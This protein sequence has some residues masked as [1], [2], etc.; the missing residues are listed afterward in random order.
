MLSVTFISFLGSLAVAHAFTASSGCGVALPAGTKQGSTGSSNS[1]SITSGGRTRSFLLHVPTNYNVN[2]AR[3]LIFSFSGRG[4]TASQQEQ[5]SG[6]SDPYFNPDLLA[7]YPSGVGNQ[8]QGDPAA[9]TDDVQFTL[10]MIDYLAPRYCINTDG[11]YASGKS[12]GGGFSANILACNSTAAQRIAAFASAS[13][14]YC[15]PHPLLSPP[16]SLSTNCTVQTKTSSTTS[17]TQT[18]SPSPATPTA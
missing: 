5:L 12:N 17:A 16:F 2:D 7:V 3:G 8:W 6:F 4:K 15:K 9:T 10:D 13:G 1:I 18:L 11:I 14:A